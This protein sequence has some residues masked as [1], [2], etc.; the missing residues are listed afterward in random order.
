MMARITSLAVQPTGSSPS[1]LIR[2]VLGFFCTS[3]W[4]ASTCSTSEVPMPKASAPKAPWVVVWLSPQTIVVP[5]RVKPCSGPITCTMPWRTSR[6]PNSSTPN[7]S[8][9]LV[10]VSTWRREISSSDRLRAVAGR[11]VVVGHRQGRVG[12]ADR[13]AG[14]PQAL[15]GLRAGDLVDQVAVDVEEAGAV[16]LRID[17]MGVPD[18]LKQRARLGHAPASL[19][20]GAYSAAVFAGRSSRRSAMRADL[21]VRPRR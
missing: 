21:P 10:S 20:P 16:G 7:S 8:Q 18:L 2:I 12:A 3:V 19:D 11:H 13:A 15:E 1:T 17:E 4:V 14:Q 6:M 9:L 5:G